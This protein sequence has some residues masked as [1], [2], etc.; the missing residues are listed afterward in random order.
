LSAA[1]DTRAYK[2]FYRQQLDELMQ[3]R[4]RQKQQEAAQTIEEKRNYNTRV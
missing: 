4:S 3:E 1:G 2:Q